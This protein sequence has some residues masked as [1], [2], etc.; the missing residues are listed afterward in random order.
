MPVCVC[1]SA[2]IM[3]LRMPSPACPITLRSCRARRAWPSWTGFRRACGGCSPAPSTAASSPRS[4]LCGLAGFLCSAVP[5]S[6]LHCLAA[7]RVPGSPSIVEFFFMVFFLVVVV[8]MFFITPAALLTALKAGVLRGPGHIVLCPLS[9]SGPASAGPD[10]RERPR[11]EPGYRA[12]ARA[13]SLELERGLSPF[14]WPAASTAPASAR[15][16]ARAPS[17]RLGVPPDRLAGRSPSCRGSR[18]RAPSRTASRRR[19]EAAPS[20]RLRRLSGRLRKCSPVSICDPLA[21]NF[22]LRPRV[23]AA[24]RLINASPGPGPAT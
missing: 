24:Q 5:L 19:L 12:R 8:E 11:E 6:T 22:R 7:C 9:L 4:G 14:R 13:G 3:V 21:Q 17:F 10:T 16:E 1:R 20:V 2:S 18:P 23:K 15:G